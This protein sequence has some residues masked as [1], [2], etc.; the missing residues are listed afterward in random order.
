VIGLQACG[1]AHHWARMLGKLGHEARLMPPAYVK[2]FV[3]RNKSDAIDAAACCKAV[4]D[5]D[6]RFVPVKTVEQQAAL[7][8]HR[9]RELLVKEHSVL[10][11][12]IK[13]AG[14]MGDLGHAYHRG[15][16]PL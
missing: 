11:S 7:A 3:K 9:S 6:M 8:L 13:R 15:Q 10:S 1:S 16:R 5:V 14:V 2:P 12:P 4:T